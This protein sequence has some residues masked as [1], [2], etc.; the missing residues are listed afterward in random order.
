MPSHQP[1][2]WS[3]QIVARRR[4][5]PDCMLPVFGEVIVTQHDQVPAVSARARVVHD[6]ACVGLH[7][8][9]LVDGAGD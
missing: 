3:A 4:P 2:R 7:A 8:L 1:L 5:A 9:Q 6:T